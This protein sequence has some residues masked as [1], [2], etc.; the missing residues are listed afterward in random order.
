MSVSGRIFPKDR[1]HL[2]ASVRNSEKSTRICTVFQFTPAFLIDSNGAT[3]TTKGVAKAV[4]SIGG[5]ETIAGKLF[6]GILLA[7]AGGLVDDGIDLR[8]RG[9]YSSNNAEAAQEDED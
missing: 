1:Y 5:D 4:T 2:P 6:V 8:G 7:I 9:W 3:E